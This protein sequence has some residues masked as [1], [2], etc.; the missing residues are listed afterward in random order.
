MKLGSV[1]QVCVI[2]Y[3][4]HHFQPQ[5][6]FLLL[7][8]THVP[9]QMLFCDSNYLRHKLV[10][11]VATIPPRGP[12]RAWP[13]SH[14]VSLSTRSQCSL[15]LL[16][17]SGRCS[18]LGPAL[19]FLVPQPDWSKGN[20]LRADAMPALCLAKASSSARSPWK[21]QSHRSK[22]SLR[23]RTTLGCR[24][25]NV[26]PTSSLVKAQYHFLISG[27]HLFPRGILSQSMPTI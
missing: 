25:S 12:V 11:E 9:L 22:V 16:S 2:L 10:Q 26:R 8:T 21:P 13:Q 19:P 1:G 5:Q 18:L 7:I 15:I 27:A 20:L 17:S 4:Q 3:Q 23:G 6:V 24:V 14:I